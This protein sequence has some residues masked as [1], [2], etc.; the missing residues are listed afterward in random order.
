MKTLAILL[1]GVTAAVAQTP[2]PSPTP[3][4]SPVVRPEPPSP[5]VATPKPVIDPDV[6]G[7]TTR[8]MQTIQI[9]IN[10][11]SLMAKA[12]DGAIHPMIDGLDVMNFLKSKSK[13]PAAAPTPTLSPTNT[14]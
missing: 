4:P 10:G 13:S 7:L 9:F 6:V 3:I 5:P 2:T 12:Q 11:S 14:Q 8:D 1:A